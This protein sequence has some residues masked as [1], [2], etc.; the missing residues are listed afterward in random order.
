MEGAIPDQFP[1]PIEHIEEM[2]ISSNSSQS[3]QG[4][5]AEK[6]VQIMSREYRGDFLVYTIASSSGC[7]GYF[8]YPFFY[9]EAYVFSVKTYFLCRISNWQKRVYNVNSNVTSCLERSSQQLFDHHEQ[10]T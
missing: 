10:I 4:T 3:L 1:R 2:P 7:P 6:K 9:G 8:T 5:C